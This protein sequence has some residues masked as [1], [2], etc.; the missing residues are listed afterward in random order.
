M[1]VVPP[2]PLPPSP[3]SL[4]VQSLPLKPVTLPSVLSGIRQPR[5]DPVEDIIEKAE[6]WFAAG[7]KDYRAGHLEIAKKEFNTAIDGIL[8]APVSM[9]EER[10]LA[11]A[12]DSLIDRIHSYELEALQQGDGFAEPKYQPAPLDELQK[13]TFPDNPQLSERFRA[14]AAHTV[15]DLPLVVNNQVANFIEY[16]A[17]GRGRSSLEA[18][19]RRAGRFHDMIVRILKEE[20]VP[21]DLIYL[22][23]AE[24]A[25]QYYARSNKGATGVWQFMAATARPYGLE[26][27]W[28]LDERLN[29][30]KATRAA[31][32]HLRDLHNMFGDWYLALAAYNCG[33]MGVQRAVE[34][35]GYADFWKLSARHVLPEETRNYVPIILA[36]TI[37]AKNPEKYGLENL[38]PEVP[39]VYDTVTVTAPVDLRLVSEI[40]G[41][42]VEALRELNPSLLRLTTP[43]VAEYDLRIPLATKDIFLKRIA[44]IPPEKRVWWR[45]HTVSYGETLSGIAKKLHSTP[46]AIAEVNNL[47][48]QQPLREAAE[49]VIPVS[50]A[51]GTAINHQVRAKETL[52]SLARHYRVSTEDLMTW[53]NLSSPTVR[54]GT[55]L[56]IPSP[57]NRA[58][59]AA[60]APLSRSTRSKAG[61]VARRK[62]AGPARAAVKY[63]VR[64]GESL[65][66]IAANHNVSVEALKQRNSHL[67]DT[68]RIGAEI[69]IP[70]AK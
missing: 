42:S 17:H 14:D 13:L 61:H 12:F 1:A 59:A 27:G 3:P 46:Q 11:K 9:K 54:P 51:A 7:K 24:S 21:L 30:E 8:Q 23:Q 52:A 48:S 18:G 53:N 37:I 55:I 31:A 40:V 63:K 41:S 57:A 22:A 67:G 49:L 64:K 38:L 26:T 45:W 47:D 10:R 62:S 6:T 33:P 58:K 43:K 16:F 32:K 66:Q 68:L 25:F 35:T 34:R 15:S 19:L 70:A 36:L 65:A 5:F 50:P 39:L 20:G 56:V 44:M 60:A 28:W 29:P 69:L 4:T 2:P